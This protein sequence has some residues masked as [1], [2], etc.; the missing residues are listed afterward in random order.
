MSLWNDLQERA[1]ARVFEAIERGSRRILL[2]MPTG[3]GK[4][5]C[6]QTMIERYLRAGKKASFLSNRKLLVEQTAGVMERGGVS[7]G[8]RMAGAKP[9]LDLR[10]QVSSIQTEAQR[11]LKTSKWSLHDASLVVIDEAHLNAGPTAAKLVERHLEREDCVLVGLTA[12]PLDL[13]HFYDELIVAASVSEGRECG[14]LVYAHS[15]GPEQPDLKQI[16]RVSLG[17]DLTE[18]QNRSVMGKVTDGKPDQKIWRLFGRVVEWWK[19]LNPH[20]KPTILFAPGVAESVWFAEEFCKAGIPAAHIDGADVWFD[21]VFHESSR[22]ARE[23][24]L[25]GLRYG[26]FKVLC[27]RFVLREGLDV[28]EVEHLVFATVVGS[29]QSFIQMGGRG[30]RSCPSSGKEKLTVQDHGG[31]VL[32]H[33]SLNADREWKLEY[34]CGAVQAMRE[35]RLREKKEPEP[36]PCPACGAYLNSVV[37]YNCGH[38]IDIR[39]KSRMVVQPDGS[40]KEYHG[41]LYRPRVTK[42]EPDTVDKWR[43]LYW[44]ARN[45][46]M[47][48][49]Q[50]YSL[51]LIDHGYYP[52]RDLPLMPRAEFDWCRKVS[53]VAWEDLR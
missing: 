48:F 22:K 37:C 3:L 32:R 18:N 6:A 51:Y 16:G 11:V 35:E 39:R 28:P 24:A 41:D 4:T 19:K 9:E 36:F 33:G 46:G 21:G 14:A 1:V 8:V 20:E 40:L 30:M 45:G 42:T 17:D 7:H 15:F 44:R 34:T 38:K 26:R 49:R 10:L 50:A 2:S 23:E 47:T 12:T 52:P 53:E 27:N 31:S 43:K 25:D 5:R 13:A 29:V